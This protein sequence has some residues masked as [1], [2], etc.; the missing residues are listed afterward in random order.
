[1]RMY[2][3]WQQIALFAIFDEAKPMRCGMTRLAAGVVVI[4]VIGGCQL[5]RPLCVL[6]TLGTHLQIG[7]LDPTA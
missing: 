3:A 2:L 4:V 5:A 1:M 6:P 7:V